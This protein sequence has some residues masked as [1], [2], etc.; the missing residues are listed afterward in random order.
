MG[1][2]ENP[3]RGPITSAAI[4]DN[5]LEPDT[6]A[7]ENNIPGLVDAIVEYYK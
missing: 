7:T 1:T 5:D 6:E 4:C 3:A 2:R